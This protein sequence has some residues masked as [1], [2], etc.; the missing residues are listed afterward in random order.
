MLYNRFKYILCSVLLC[1][2][3][4]CTTE[5]EICVD[6]HHQHLAEVELVYDLSKVADDK[7]DFIPDSMIIVAYR[8][9]RSWKC[10]YLSP[11]DAE[12]TI[13][14]Y[15]YNKPYTDL[16]V[17]DPDT[18]DQPLAGEGTGE[19]E[20]AS[21]E[22]DGEEAGDGNNASGSNETTNGTQERFLVKNGEYRFIAF[23][24]VINSDVFQDNA[25]SRWFEFS[26]VIDSVISNKEIN[27]FYRDYEL[28]ND[29]VNIY[30]KEWTDFNPYTTYIS[31]K[32]NPIYFQYSDVYD[33]SNTHRNEVTLELEQVTQDIELRFSIER[34]SVIIENIVAELSGIPC[35]MNLITKKLD[36]TKTY[37]MLFDVSETEEPVTGEENGWYGLSE[38]VGNVNVIGL[39]ASN[40][41]KLQTGP[42]I[43]RLAIYAYTIDSAGEKKPKIFNVGINLYNTIHKY[44]PIISGYNE[45]VILDIDNILTIKK[46]EVIESSDIDNNLD[47]WIIYDDIHIDI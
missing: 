19:G 4:A 45:K 25:N 6:E 42:G 18:G 5:V 33:I 28:K 11:L 39:A 20:N 43:L 46:D 17:E 34:D 29:L 27:I 44:A 22:Q 21:G 40:N 8:V 3:Q 13:G 7:V 24:N 26:G 1:M 38:F 30:G 9:I 14:R 31:S 32:S 35:G 2:L 37:K 23:N 47:T 36:I 10:T 12:S 16:F 41:K 15:I